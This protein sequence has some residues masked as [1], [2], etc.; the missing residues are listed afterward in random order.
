ME[1]EADLRLFAQWHVDSGDIDPVY[2][3]LRWIEEDVCID[4][5]EAVALTFLY[6]AYYDL[7][8]AVMTWLDGWRPGQELD[9]TQLKRPTGT[10][11]RAH[12]DPAQFAPHVFE[13]GRMLR[14]DFIDVM[15]KMNWWE[16]QD[17]LAR[18]RGNGRWAAYKTGEM[19]GQV[20]DWEIEPLDAGH[21]NSSGPRKGLA[22]V[23]PDMAL[24]GNRA[25]V[26]RRLDTRT[27]ELAAALDLPVRQVETVL[28]DWH[29]TLQG[30]YYVGHDID[31]MLEQSLRPQ[32][33]D[34]IRHLIIDA[35]S[36]SF[37]SRWLGEEHGWPG[38]RRELKKR[39]RDRGELIWWS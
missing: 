36:D 4:E 32:V 21:A 16:L 12:R 9:W 5:N 10:E 17:E 22:D 20:N 6:V 11:R 37:N 8:S 34:H 29:S 33:P 2:P 3:V 39:Y 35:R 13:L 27:A 38:I 19:L 24:V 25:S 31:L 28:C 14:P 26:I 15:R 30:G 23:Y 7:T 18:W 1:R